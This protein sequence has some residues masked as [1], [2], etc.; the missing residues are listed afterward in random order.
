MKKIILIVAILLTG[1]TSIAGY[2]DLFIYPNPAHEEMYVQLPDSFVGITNIIILD[3]NGRI[4]YQAERSLDA[5]E[6]RKTLI[7]VVDLPNG[8]YLLEI[9]NNENAVQSEFMKQ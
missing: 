2:N 6:F 3:L 4:I 8:V 5:N 7:P 1:L 9:T